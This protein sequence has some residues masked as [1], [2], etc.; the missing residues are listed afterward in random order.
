MGSFSASISPN[1]SVLVSSVG[2][3]T[4][5]EQSGKDENMSATPIIVADDID[6]QLWSFINPRNGDESSERAKAQARV[7]AS[8]A[9]LQL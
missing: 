8:L 3:I 9:E 1:M 7:A 4:V 6:Q 2:D 5:Y